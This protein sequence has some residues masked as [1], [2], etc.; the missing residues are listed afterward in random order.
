MTIVECT[1]EGCANNERGKCKLRRIAL[2]VVDELLECC[3]YEAKE[4]G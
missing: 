4:D 1:E 2:Q 3:D